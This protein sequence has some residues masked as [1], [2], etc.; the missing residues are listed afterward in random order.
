MS[1]DFETT[2]SAVLH[3]ATGL[4]TWFIK[5]PG[6]EGWFADRSAPIPEAIFESTATDDDARITRTGRDEFLIESTAGGFHQLHR[7]LQSDKPSQQDA[8]GD[9]FAMP[10]QDAVYCVS[11]DRA[12]EVL[13]QMCGVNWQEVVGEQLV[14]TRVAGVNCAVRRQSVDETPW[15]VLRVDPAYAAYLWG[16]LLTICRELGGDSADV[17]PIFPELK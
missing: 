3:D 7:D 1:N 6:A 8:G 5:G 4:P 9:L 2:L 17:G 16:Q 10:R 15:F 12:A 13:S 14:M 11:G